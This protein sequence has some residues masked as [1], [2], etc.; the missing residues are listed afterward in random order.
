MYTIYI[1]AFLVGLCFGSFASVI[2]Y[3]LHDKSRG[4]V[5][6]RSHCPKCKHPLAAKD[7]IPIVSFVVSGRKCRYCRKP[8]SFTYP[9]LE[10]TMGTGFVLTTI[11]TGV[12]TS[13]LLAYYL[14]LTFIFVTISYYDVLFQEIPDSLS[15]PTIVLAGLIGYFGR[16]NTLSSLGIGFAIPVAFFGVLFMVSRGRWL[17]GGDIRIGALIGLVLGWPNIIVA[18]FLAYLLGSIFSA[19]GLIFGKLTR[20]S[21]IPFGP[22]LFLGAYITLFWG[23]RILEWYLNLV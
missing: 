20:K 11:L 14:F 3:R 18:L 2:I 15:L 10:L 5:W 23:Q 1:L 16:L 12:Q 7:L 22:F 19:L 9:L 13:W 4:F 6:G 17:G 8:I 21:P